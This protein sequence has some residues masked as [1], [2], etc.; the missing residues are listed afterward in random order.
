MVGSLVECGS[1]L[2]EDFVFEGSFGNANCFEK[3]GS[4]SVGSDFGLLFYIVP[5]WFVLHG[6]LLEFFIGFQDRWLVQDL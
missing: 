2:K 6:R 4:C 5:R 3:V 1:Y